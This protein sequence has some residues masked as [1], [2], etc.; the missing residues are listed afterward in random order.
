M[1]GHVLVSSWPDALMLTTHARPQDEAQ[2]QAQR[3]A[4][5]PA[6]LSSP[7]GDNR[8]GKGIRLAEILRLAA[9]DYDNVHALPELCGADPRPT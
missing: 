2:D 8:S 1:S 5:R 4:P 3:C 6:R 7:E 9:A